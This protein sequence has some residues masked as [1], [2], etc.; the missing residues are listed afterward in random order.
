M[1]EVIVSSADFNGD[2]VSHRFLDFPPLEKL[3]NDAEHALV[4]RLVR[5]PDAEREVVLD[6]LDQQRPRVVVEE[7]GLDLALGVRQTRMKLVF[8]N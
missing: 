1:V 6:G 8:L 7:A 5:L 4:P 2:F 3:W